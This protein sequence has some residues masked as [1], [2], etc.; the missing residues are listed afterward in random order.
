MA[1]TVRMLQTDE[2]AQTHHSQILSA[3]EAAMARVEHSSAETS[4]AIS[5]DM[6]SCHPELIREM[7]AM[8]FDVNAQVDLTPIIQNIEG[9]HRLVRSLMESRGI[10]KTFHSISDRSLNTSRADFK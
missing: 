3:I 5:E 7:R 2:T 4:R 8:K 9:V 10:A 1:D 6:K